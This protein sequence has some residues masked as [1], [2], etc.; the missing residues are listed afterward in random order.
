MSGFTV[1]GRDRAPGPAF[2]FDDSVVTFSRR[3]TVSPSSIFGPRRHQC[4]SHDGTTHPARSNL[5]WVRQ[6]VQDSVSW[7]AGLCR[8][9]ALPIPA[10]GLWLR[11]GQRDVAESVLPAVESKAATGYVPPG[12]WG[13]H[14]LQAI[15]QISLSAWQRPTCRW[16]QGSS[17][18]TLRTLHPRLSWRSLHSAC[19]KTP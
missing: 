19:P 6:G 5:A 4:P 15:D 8:R 2:T 12:F 16:Q 7:N 11:G 18:E 17:S 14:R 13:H 9:L 3:F 1:G 10:F